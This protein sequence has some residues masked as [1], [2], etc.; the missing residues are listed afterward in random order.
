MTNNNTKKFYYKATRDIISVAIG[1]ILTTIGFF[2]LKA[3][4][5]LL[6]E[7]DER[8]KDIKI[9]CICTYLIIA[10][11]LI[12]GCLV[13]TYIKTYSSLIIKQNNIVYNY[14]WMT[15]KT[16]TIP[17]CKIRSCSKSI[18]I[19]QRRCGTMDIYITTAGDV[20][21]IKFSNI[22]NGEEAYKELV[23]LAR[24]NEH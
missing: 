24:A 16:V 6:E 2:I 12:V 5:S 15:K 1:T 14:G 7:G 20:S 8:I 10:T 9:L 17:V 21:E 18:G 23:Q 13:S 4:L 19:L 22:K 11:P 3:L